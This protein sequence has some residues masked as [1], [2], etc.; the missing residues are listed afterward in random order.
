MAPVQE[1]APVIKRAHMVQVM[2]SS[3]TS[4][5]KMHIAAAP[6]SRNAPGSRSQAEYQGGCSAS[7]WSNRRPATKTISAPAS[8]GTASPA[9]HERGTEPAAAATSGWTPASASVAGTAKARSRRIALAGGTVT[10]SWLTGG[11]APSPA[12]RITIP[13][14]APSG[15]REQDMVAAGG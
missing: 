13:P 8:A 3:S 1:S 6:A 9:A 7:P 14:S 11:L 2:T 12:E 5:P 10:A 15:D 4:A